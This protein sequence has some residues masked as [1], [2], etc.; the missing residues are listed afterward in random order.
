M[1][2]KEEIT[3]YM[4][5]YKFSGEK[6]KLELQSKEVYE[7]LVAKRGE[8]EMGDIITYN[9]FNYGVVDAVDKVLDYQDKTTTDIATKFSGSVSYFKYTYEI[10]QQSKII[11]FSGAK[12]IAE[13]I[14][15]VDFYHYTDTT[16]VNFVS[17]S[18]RGLESRKGTVDD[19]T[20][21]INDGI[22]QKVFINRSEYS[23]RQ[24]LVFEED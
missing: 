5:I 20:D 9:Q 3:Y 4:E 21:L 17:I 23:I 14:G 16:P 24:I 19:L 6:V 11:G 15:E 13:S 12:K 7:R 18:P 22:P 10:N 1:N 8:L 2:H